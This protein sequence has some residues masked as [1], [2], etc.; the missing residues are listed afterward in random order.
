MYYNCHIHVFT[1]D[2]V[3]DG[4]LPL[5]IV[6]PLRD[7]IIN[8]ISQELLHT[9]FP[10]TDNDILDRYSEFIRT[11]ELGSQRKIF[12]ECAK[13]YPA[14]TIYNV[15]TMDMDF[16]GAGEVPREYED[17]LEELCK[18]TKIYPN[19]NAFVHIDPRR[20]N[21]LGLFKKCVEE[22]GFKGLKIYCNLGYFPYDPRL[23]E[24]YKYCEIHNLPVIAHFSPYNPVHYKGKMKELRRLLT[25]SQIGLDMSSCSK[26]VLCSE[27]NHP[28]QW[29]IMFKLF[30]NLNVCL[31][32]FGSESEWVDYIENKKNIN[33]NW[34]NLAIQLLKKYPNVYTDISFSVNNSDLWSDLSALLDDDKLKNKILFGSDWYMN[35]TSCGEY[36]FAKEL[37]N[38]LGPEKFKLISEINPKRF[39]KIA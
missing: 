13:Y 22:W 4:F 6:R 26:K 14:D 7:K 35:E 12:E 21:C 33:K 23:F 20:S 25:L 2:D 10:L 28:Q 27:F 17:Q 36:V 39:L 32:H 1:S 30:P 34:H 37:P 5:G 15:L 24:I 29:E 38:F 3:P 16:M 31:A 8:G 11:G 9:I 18:L 19:I